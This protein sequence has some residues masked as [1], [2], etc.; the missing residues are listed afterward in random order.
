MHTKDENLQEKLVSIKR[1]LNSYSTEQ[2]FLQGHKTAIVNNMDKINALVASRFIEQDLRSVESIIAHSKDLMTKVL[3]ASSF[4]EIAALEPTFRILSYLWK[5]PPRIDYYI[6]TI[7]KH[8]HRNGIH[9]MVDWHGNRYSW[10][11]P[12]VLFSLLS[13][14]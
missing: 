10:S 9:S 11:P 12:S 2:K 7:T 6:F 4:D 14:H 13:H 5:I 1:E 3:N 8:S